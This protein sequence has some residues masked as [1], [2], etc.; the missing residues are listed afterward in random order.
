MAYE[1]WYAAEEGSA[2]TGTGKTVDSIPPGVYDL[3]VVPNSGT[4]WVPVDRRNDDV[5][6]FPETPVDEVVADIQ[7]FWDREAAFVSHGLPYKR[8]ILLYGPP[9][10]GKTCTLELVVRD[11]V[12]RGGVVA[13][14]SGPAV[15]LAG[16][17]MLRAIQPETPLV[18]LMEDIDGILT[19]T[20]QSSILN[21]LD[22]VEAIHKV[23][24]LATTNYPE[25]LQERIANRPSRFDRKVH[26][27]HPNEESRRLYLETIALPNDDVDLGKYAKDTVGLSL[28]HLKELFVSTVLLGTPYDETLRTL[29]AMRDRTTSFDDNPSFGQY[30]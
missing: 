20:T 7:R 2:Y 30:A 18:V 4:F 5:L 21:L 19:P 10:S 8:G 26:I 25:H 11:V 28:A 27:P 23:V 16:Y 12:A 29:R 13:M 22:G 14:F 3:Q 15:F 9:G 24:F 6:R 17:R 1:Q